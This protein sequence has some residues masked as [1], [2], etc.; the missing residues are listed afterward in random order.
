MRLQPAKRY[1]RACLRILTPFSC[2]SAT[3]AGFWRK[4]LSQKGFEKKLKI[5][6]VLDFTADF[7][8]KTR[9]VSRASLT[10]RY[11]IEKGLRAVKLVVV[12]LTNTQ[13]SPSFLQMA[14]DGQSP[15][16]E[17]RLHSRRAPPAAAAAAHLQH[18]MPLLLLPTFGA[19]GRG[20][21]LTK[22]G[23]VG[24]GKHSLLTWAPVTIMLPNP[25]HFLF[26]LL[27]TCGKKR[28]QPGNYFLRNRGF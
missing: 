19:A 23:A 17:S 8:L 3:N 13:R 14:A 22:E 9:Q 6:R 26:S 5:G 2:I 1:F 16:A 27:S 20:Q 11:K 15:T 21:Q 28:R 4:N 24:R 7:G 12:W 10:V 25:L 18:Q